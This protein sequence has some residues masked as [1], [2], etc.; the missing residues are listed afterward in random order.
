MIN[1]SELQ[2]GE[3]PGKQFKKTAVQRAIETPEG[4]HL[5]QDGPHNMDA[6][7]AVTESTGRGTKRIKGGGGQ[8][9]KGFG[10]HRGRAKKKAR[11]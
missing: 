1:P 7:N 11:L 10:K 4:P 3:E 9:R 6:Y 8:L 2:G 5:G